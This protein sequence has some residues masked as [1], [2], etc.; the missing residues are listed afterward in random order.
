[1]QSIVALS[2]AS[3]KQRFYPTLIAQYHGLSKGGIDLLS[4]FGLL[5]PATSFYRERLTALAD[6]S[7][8]I[9]YFFSHRYLLISVLGKSR[10]N[11]RTLVGGTTFRKCTESRSQIC[12][13]RIWLT[14]SG[15]ELRFESTW[16]T[17]RCQWHASPTVVSTWM[18]CHLTQWRAS[19]SS[20][21]QWKSYVLTLEK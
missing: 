8:N 6:V 11:R 17:R 4:S 20:F 19:V 10:T 13:E 7:N 2:K 21:L 9:Q 14:A 5:M 3:K 12:D 16:A 15:L 18:R 1:M